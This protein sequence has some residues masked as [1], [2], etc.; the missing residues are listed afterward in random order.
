MK[1]TY[2]SPVIKYTEMV[3]IILTSGVKIDG[4]STP[5]TINPEGTGK[6]PS[7]DGKNAGFDEYW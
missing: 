2:K 3:D 6:E 1:K 5:F 4:K 7:V